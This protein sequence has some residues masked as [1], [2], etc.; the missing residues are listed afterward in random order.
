MPFKS[1]K[2][3]RFM[4]AEKRRGGLKGVNLKEWAEST[5][6]SSLPETVKKA[7]DQLAPH[8]AKIAARLF[9]PRKSPPV[10]AR[11]IQT[12]MIEAAKEEKM[13]GKTPVEYR[14]DLTAQRKGIV[15]RNKQSAKA[16]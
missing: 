16:G 5:D 11:V 15:Q 2:Q 8:F 9:D 6:F 13:G 10:P 7:Q 4:F 14:N 1:K 12:K 3:V